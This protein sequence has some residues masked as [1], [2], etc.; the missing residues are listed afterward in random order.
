[1]NEYE[2][3]EAPA[4]ASIPAFIVVELRSLTEDNV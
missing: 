2:R 3:I 1:M 4:S